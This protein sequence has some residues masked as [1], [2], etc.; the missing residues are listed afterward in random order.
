MRKEY[1]TEI[2]TQIISDSR[3]ISKMNYKYNQTKIIKNR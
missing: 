2:V 1:L 3:K